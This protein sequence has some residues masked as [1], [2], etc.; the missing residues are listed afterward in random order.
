MSLILVRKSFPKN[1]SK[2]ARAPIKKLYLLQEPN[3]VA[4]NVPDPINSDEC[5]AGTNS[6]MAVT[7]ETSPSPSAS[8][9]PCSTRKTLPDTPS[10]SIQTSSDDSNATGE[11]SSASDSEQQS[12]PNPKPQHEQ[13]D[14]RIKL[15]KEKFW[16]KIG[17]N[18]D[19]RIAALVPIHVPKMERL[20]RLQALKQRASMKP[21]AKAREGDIVTGIM[22]KIDK[23]AEINYSV[24]PVGAEFVME[25]EL[26]ANKSR[27]IVTATNNPHTVRPKPPKIIQRRQDKV[28]PFPQRRGSAYKNSGGQ[29]IGYNK[30]GGD[31]DS[32]TGS[33]ASWPTDQDEA[34]PSF[35][36]PNTKTK[37]A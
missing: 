19:P 21:K 32:D 6:Q 17:Q 15:Q 29:E 12:N 20:S 35:R 27:V 33:D 9:S 4:N 26:G 8:T 25:D 22:Q 36:T 37:T 2:R 31:N 10:L 18:T 16:K 5:T 34:I 13:I 1:P 24:V 23:T 30:G 28:L 14:P 3:K 7:E 11:F